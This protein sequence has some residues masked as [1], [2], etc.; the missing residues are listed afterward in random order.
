MN[1]EDR[2]NRLIGITILGFSSLVVA[3]EVALI[4]LLRNT[5]L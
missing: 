1:E 3:L 4:V 2:I 5:G